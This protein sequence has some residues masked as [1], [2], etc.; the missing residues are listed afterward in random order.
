M[1]MIDRYNQRADAVN[2]LLCVGLDSALDKLRSLPPLVTSWE[3]ERL[4]KLIAE[5]QDGKRF[6]LQGGNCA[7]TLA[8]CRPEAIASKLKILAPSSGARN[9]FTT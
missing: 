3:I 1:P 8:D 4:R 7:E 2:S 5:A 9:G 6:V